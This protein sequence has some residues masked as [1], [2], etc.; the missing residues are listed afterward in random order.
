M[1]NINEII[2]NILYLE[3]QNVKFINEYSIKYQGNSVDYIFE[4]LNENK[5]FVNISNQSKELREQ[6][7][8]Y[9]ITNKIYL[10]GKNTD[11]G[12]LVDTSRVVKDNTYV[13]YA[14][15]ALDEISDKLTCIAVDYNSFR[16]Y[17]KFNIKW[18]KRNL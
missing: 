1:T 6:F 11:N 4:R 12:F 15:T 5:E 3:E 18:Q 13:V 14:Y 2:E 7:G 17:I 10:T 9:L 8:D 16:E